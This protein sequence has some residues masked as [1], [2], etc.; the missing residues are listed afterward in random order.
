MQ[1]SL[2]QVMQDNTLGRDELR[3]FQE[4]LA[5]MKQALMDRLWISFGPPRDV[6]DDSEIDD[7]LD[8]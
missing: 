5:R 7:D 6:S 3:D 2:L 4:R 1:T 8:N